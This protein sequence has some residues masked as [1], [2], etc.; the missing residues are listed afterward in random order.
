MRSK[1]NDTSPKARAPGID[2]L[3]P[4]RLFA[5]IYGEIEPNQRA[6]DA[7]Y[8]ALDASGAWNYGF[9]REDAFLLVVFITDGDDCSLVDPGALEGLTMEAA[10]DIR[11]AAL[12]EPPLASIA[13]S[14]D[15]IRPRDPKMLIGAVIGGTPP[16]LAQLE[17]ALP[18]RYTYTDIAGPHWSDA[19]AQ[20]AGWGPP[21]G[22]QCLEEDI[23][24][25][26]A[27]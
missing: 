11:C 16:R 22:N 25:V 21:R 1:H 23:D 14:I 8:V 6:S 26:P 13:D 27:L 18:E 4:R 5:A 12:A 19:L 10:V 15:W 3:E 20:L 17:A 2:P 7:I 24:P 9:R